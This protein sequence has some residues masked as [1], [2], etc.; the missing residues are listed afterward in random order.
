M[1]L[2][3]TEC[4]STILRKRDSEGGEGGNV[5]ASTSAVFSDERQRSMFSAQLRL[6]SENQAG[7]SGGNAALATTWF[8]LC[9]TTSVQ[10]QTWLQNASN[11]EVDQR[12]RSSYDWSDK[13]YLTLMCC[14]NL[15]VGE[16]AADGREK[17][18]VGS[19]FVLVLLPAAMP[20]V[21]RRVGVASTAAMMHPTDGILGR[22]W[23]R[24]FGCVAGSVA[25]ALEE[26][27]VAATW[28]GSASSCCGGR[29]WQSHDPRL[30]RMWGRGAGDATSNAGRACRPS[31]Q[32]LGAPM[33]IRPKS[34]APTLIVPNNNGK[35][36]DSIERV[37][38]LSA[39]I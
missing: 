18:G 31:R 17:S 34:S 20:R 27:P 6:A 32:G 25:D 23:V 30:A 39:Y 2:S 4:I 9:P 12:Y 10:S 36:K 33:L 38:K 3:Y 14:L 26:R 5:L 8:P 16:F 21:E 37:C 22:I 15:C 19:S 28:R 11:S 13:P 7:L 1:W 29:P 24:V 35:I